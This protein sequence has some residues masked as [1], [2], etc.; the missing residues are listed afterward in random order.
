MGSDSVFIE[1][2]DNPDS[3]PSDGPNMIAL[4][5][6]PPL[7]ARLKEFDALAKKS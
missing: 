3:A 2:H 6:L 7:L 4:K 1:T 5:D